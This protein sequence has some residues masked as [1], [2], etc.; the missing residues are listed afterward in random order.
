MLTLNE[1]KNLTSVSNSRLLD[2]LILFAG[3]ILSD[4]LSS[5]QEIPLSNA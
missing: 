3:L 2:F 1:Q 5:A 4:I